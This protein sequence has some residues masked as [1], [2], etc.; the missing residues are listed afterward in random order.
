MGLYENYPD[1]FNQIME[2][3]GQD[4]LKSDFKKVIKLEAGK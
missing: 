4:M 3:I 1:N 2:K